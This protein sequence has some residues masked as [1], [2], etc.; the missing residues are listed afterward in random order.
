MLSNKHF[1]LSPPRNGGLTFLQP[2][3]LASFF[4][5]AAQLQ[6]EA[7]NSAESFPVLPMIPNLSHLTRQGRSQFARG[8]QPLGRCD[9]AFAQPDVHEVGCTYY[10][11][12]RALASGVALPVFLSVA[13]KKFEKTSLRRCAQGSA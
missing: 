6:L 13:T 9:Q 10:Q 8:L 1:Q 5:Y 12:Q 7:T 2:S 3:R 4:C 11:S